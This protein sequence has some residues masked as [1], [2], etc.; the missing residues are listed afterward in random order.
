M[1]RIRQQQIAD[2]GRSAFNDRGASSPIISWW[3]PMNCPCV[4]PSWNPSPPPRAQRKRAAG[5]EAGKGG[6]GGQGGAQGN[7]IQSPYAKAM[8]GHCALAPPPAAAPLPLHP[9][10]STSTSCTPPCHVGESSPVATRLPETTACLTCCLSPS[11]LLPLRTFSLK[12]HFPSSP[13]AKLAP[14]YSQIQTVGNPVGPVRF[15]TCSSRPKAVTEPT[16][17]MLGD[18]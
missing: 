14:D 13:T 10:P 11:H 15:F 7:M 2:L 3:I 17:A 16:W 9:H 12:L 5:G 1:N 6:R 4:T 8:S 18:D